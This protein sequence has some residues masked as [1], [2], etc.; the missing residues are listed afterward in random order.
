MLQTYFL[1]LRMKSIVFILCLLNFG[2]KTSSQPADSELENLNSTIP[3]TV[4]GLG[5]QNAHVV[6]SKN[7]KDLVYRSRAPKTDK[8]YKEISSL[9]ITDVVIFKRET[10]KEV[11]S[12]IQKLQEA[13]LSSNHILHIPFL[14]KDFPNYETPCRQT[15]EALAAIAKVRESNRRKVLFHCTVGEDRT[16]YLAGLIKLLEGEDSVKNIFNNEMCA[17]GYSSG[18]PNKPRIVSSSIDR[19]LTPLYLKM[20]YFIDAGELSWKKIDAN[21]I[22]STDPANL[23]AFK[24]K[25]TFSDSSGYVCK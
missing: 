2:C 16:G 23:A 4:P 11:Q 5:I 6:V 10:G 21:K 7:S 9:G 20:A 3:S 18:N 22:C 19:D 8:E 15:L 1:G 17:K 13:G 24:F 12:E 25:K 14:Y